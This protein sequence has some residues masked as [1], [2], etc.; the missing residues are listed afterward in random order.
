MSR[1][2]RLRRV[3]ILHLAKIGERA[4]RF[5]PP[6][7]DSDQA[8]VA[9]D[10]VITLAE[11]SPK[12][13]ILWIVAIVSRYPGAGRYI[14]TPGAWDVKVVPVAVASDLLHRLVIAGAAEG[15]VRAAFGREADVAVGKLNA[16]AAAGSPCSVSTP[17]DQS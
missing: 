15:E 4:I 12:A 5:F 2:T 10:D 9:V 7:G 8:F 16:P 17:W 14:T 3:E 13:R 11:L 1:R 6:Q